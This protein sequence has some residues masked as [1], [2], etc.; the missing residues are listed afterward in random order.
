MIS[1]V[2]GILRGPR[3]GY[4][5]SDAV[6]AYQAAKLGQAAGVLVDALGDTIIVSGVGLGVALLVGSAFHQGRVGFAT[7]VSD[8]EAWALLAATGAVQLAVFGVGGVWV[9]KLAG[10]LLLAVYVA[11]LAFGIA[12]VVRS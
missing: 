8:A 6:A 3:T 12:W 1:P 9:G 5:A 4:N 2:T 10:G 7:S 11:H